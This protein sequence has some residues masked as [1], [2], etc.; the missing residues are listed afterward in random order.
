[1]YNFEIEE[2][3]QAIQKRYKYANAPTS[4]ETNQII[5]EVLRLHNLGYTVTE[6]KFVNII[7]KYIK[8]STR[9]LY[10]SID[11]STSR[12]IIAQIISV[13]GSNGKK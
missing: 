10:H 12:S 5:L 6:E 3:R 8:D 13:S 2:I 1:M 9:M 4:Y 11:M 7:E